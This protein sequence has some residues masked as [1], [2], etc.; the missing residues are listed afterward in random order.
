MRSR[1]EQHCTAQHSTAQHSTAQHSAIQAKL[2]PNPSVRALFP[3]DKAPDGVFSPYSCY[4]EVQVKHAI[5]SLIEFLGPVSA[6]SNV[7]QEGLLL[8]TQAMQS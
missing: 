5:G 1:T 3:A 6:I 7:R 2:A 8:S 4:I